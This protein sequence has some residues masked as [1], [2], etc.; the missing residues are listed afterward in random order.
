MRFAPPLILRTSLFQSPYEFVLYF[1]ER[2]FSGLSRDRNRSYRE[3]LRSGLVDIKK[4]D[5]ISIFQSMIRSRPLPT[6]IDFTRLFSAVAKTKWYD[7]VLGLVKQ[8]ELNGI[9][10]DIYTLSIVI[11]CFC[12][13]RELGFAFS[14]FGKMLKLGYEPDTITFSTLINGLCLEGRVSQAV[15][16]VDRMVET[17]VTPDLI[18]LNT[19]ING[20]CLQGKLSEQ[21]L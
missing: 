16:L 17:K 4:D 15:E 5:A 12:R 20:L 10:C 6:V 18:I 3:M 11:N 13:C 8:M 2:D 7:L 21:W 14:V 1:C 19:L 9:S